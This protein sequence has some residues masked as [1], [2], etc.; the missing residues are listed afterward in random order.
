MI[1]QIISHYKILEKLGEGGM[2]VVYKAEDT[3]LGR[4]VALKFPPADRLESA[5]EIERFN[6]EAR[7]VSALNDP[8][9]ATIYE[10]AEADGK[11]FIVFEYIPGGT[12]KTFAKEVHDTGRNLS[13][14]QVVQFGVQ[15]AG[16]LAHAHDNEVI[17]R[18]LKPDNLLLTDKGQVKITDFGLAKLKGSPQLTKSGSTLGTVSYMS[19]E[20]I[21]GEEL[22]ARSD[23]FSVGVILYQLATGQLPFRGEHEMAIGYSIVN[24]EPVSPKILRPELSDE[25]VGVIMRCLE[26]DKERRLG[27]AQELFDA[28]NVLL[29]KEANG[30]K[31]T[32]LGSRRARWAVLGVI[33]A[34]AIAT[35]AVIKLAPRQ[36]P[37]PSGRAWIAVLPFENLSADPDNE[38]FSDG[39]TEDIITQLSKIADLSVISRTSTMRYKN[40]D[41]SLREIGE[42][43]RVDAILEGSVRRAGEQVRITGQLIDARSDEHLW[44]E[45]YD[46]EI[47]DIFKVQSDV[48]EKIARA[49]EVR[50]TREER[51]RI[52]TE[53]T[54]DMAAYDAYLRGREFYYKYH[55]EDNEAAIAMFKKAL[56]L[57][58]EYAPAYAGLAD[59]YAQRAGRF[60]SA[61]VWLDSA[62]V[63]A[64]KAI[65]LNPELAE[66]Y[67]A[68]G[69]V[70]QIRGRFS[71]GLDA[72][73]KA[74]EY[75]PNY[76]AA[77]GNRGWT[78][79]YTGRPDEAIHWFKKADRLGG[80]GDL[81]VLHLSGLGFAY[82]LLDDPEKTRQYFEEAREIKPD[83]TILIVGKVWLAMTE[84][85]YNEIRDGI[86]KLMLLAPDHPFLLYWLGMVE[87]M[88]G[89]LSD[90]RLYFDKAIE[91]HVGIQSP[92]YGTHESHVKLAWVLGQLGE[93]DAADVLLDE[94]SNAV[95]DAVKN[96][97]ENSYQFYLLAEAE[98][99]RGNRSGALQWLQKAFDSGFIVLRLVETDPLLADL[100]DDRQ[101]K[102]MTA[103]FRARIAKKRERV[104]DNNW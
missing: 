39:I 57:D 40:T 14:E 22:D 87:I 61:D 37:T 1:G 96:G 41:K 84:E 77:V 63:V 5:E 99:I 38:Y 29:P 101:F 64:N 11:K 17:H 45:T 72:I 42:E 18:D 43:L 89:N 70:H 81:R 24:E 67:K 44:A 54:Q 56:R 26:K 8:H 52:K 103:D 91:S 34:I 74:L 62:F 82:L 31:T 75:N 79:I 76:E 60:G 86:S 51:G 94:A 27:S 83:E 97:D 32:R 85:R 100:R 58:P 10:L 65:E 36:P 2:G 4:I 48:A 80:E 19:P 95:R 98:C 66:A 55:Q 12:L 88:E 73:K 20:Q 30:K 53:P 3:R 90:A 46:R 7:A 102:E 28:L 71:K 6:R 59:A 104:E 23:L 78:A 69:L 93:S 16:G 9:I 15:I 50:L 49:L 35:I 25:L 13:T 92:F 68:L 33:A 21:R 47:K